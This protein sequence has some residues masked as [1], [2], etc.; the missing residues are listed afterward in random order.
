MAVINGYRLLLAGIYERSWSGPRTLDFLARWAKFFLTG[1]F[2]RPHVLHRPP[3]QVAVISV[4]GQMCGHWVESEAAAT[5][6]LVF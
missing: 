1:R 5:L 2:Q 4:T 6:T 3:K